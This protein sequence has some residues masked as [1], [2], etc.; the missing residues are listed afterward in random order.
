MLP[1]VPIKKVSFKAVSCGAAINKDGE[2]VAYKIYDGAYTILRFIENLKL[3]VSR[4]RSLPVY[5]VLD[6]LPFH[7]SL[8]IKV[9]ARQT[10][11]S[12]TSLLAYQANL[13]A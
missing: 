10:G 3:L 13:C 8:A 2:I 7:K 12:F 11:L 5:L 1:T 4:F 9:S 6:N